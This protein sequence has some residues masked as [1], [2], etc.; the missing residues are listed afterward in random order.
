MNHVLIINA[1]TEKIASLELQLENAKRNTRDEIEYRG[2][3]VR[4]WAIEKEA[5]FARINNMPHGVQG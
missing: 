4:E 3:L 1:L 5:L 2:D